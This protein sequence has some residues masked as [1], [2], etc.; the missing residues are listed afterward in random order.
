M[1][2]ERAG[3]DGAEGPSSR[4]GFL[5]AGKMA[6]ALIRG[7]IRDG[8]PP[9]SIRASDPDPRARASLLGET[10]VETFDS[11]AEVIQA[12]NVVVLAVKPQMMASVLAEVRPIVTVDHLV[13]SVAAGVTLAT[14]ADGL[15][16]DRR[17]ARVMP[18]TPSLVGEGAAGYCLGPGAREGD[19]AVVAGCCEAVGRAFRVPENLLDAV[20]GLS[21]SGPA[22]VY[23]II[24]ALAD[25]GVRAG[26]P[27]ETA[28]TLAAQTVLGAAKMVL[29]TGEHPGVLKDQVASP[30]G[31]TIAGLHA[32][33]RAG[34][35]A[36]MM[37]AVMASHARSVEL[38]TVAAKPGTSR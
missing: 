19:D 5:G 18:N 1:A 36:A 31:T 30:A 4:W 11:N 2:V 34:V 28:L 6:T 29:E 25:G 17:I 27:R 32:M 16:A 9:E 24:E 7:M 35:R 14:L 8:T 15:G 26:L 21:G 12:S 10:G 3:V 33:E 22:Y 38:A 23:V 20:T 37:D 13:V